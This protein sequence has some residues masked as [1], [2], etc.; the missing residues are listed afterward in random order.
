[1][2]SQSA[3]NN[4]LTSNIFRRE[5]VIKDKICTLYNQKKCPFKD[6][7]M[8][9]HIDIVC[10]EYLESKCMTCSCSKTNSKEYSHNY[11]HIDISRFCVEYQYKGE[12]KIGNNCKYIHI[13]LE[14]SDYKYIHER[15]EKEQKKTVI[16][17]RFRTPIRAF[18]L[19]KYSTIPKSIIEYWTQDG[20]VFYPI[21][22]P[23]SI[24]GGVSIATS[25]NLKYFHEL[26]YESDYGF[27]SYL[28]CSRGNVIVENFEKRTQLFEILSQLLPIIPLDLLYIIIDDY[29]DYQIHCIDTR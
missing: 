4:S 22:R 10:P 17:W 23:Y 8:F 25:K 5:I 29:S 19:T 13:K 1:M 14:D 16:I 12:C 21:Y 7:C 9:K 20:F 6:G 18:A 24:N 27:P 28:C 15:N 26:K 11:N 3:I 2:I